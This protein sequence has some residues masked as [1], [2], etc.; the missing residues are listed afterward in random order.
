M[1]EFV[2]SYVS[3]FFL[4]VLYDAIRAG[5]MRLKEQFSNQVEPEEPLSVHIKG[6]ERDI[7]EENRQ[8]DV[9][10]KAENLK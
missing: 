1:C 6:R 8:L 9:A 5:V 7:V 10:K 4:C 2:A 3:L